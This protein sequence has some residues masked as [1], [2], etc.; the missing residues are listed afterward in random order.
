MFLLFPKSFKDL[1]NFLI[2][3]DFQE[4]TLKSLMIK[5]IRILNEFLVTC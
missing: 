3:K 2:D 5:K 4:Y 1:E